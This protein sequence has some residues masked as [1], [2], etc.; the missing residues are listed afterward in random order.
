MLTYLQGEIGIRNKR[1]CT[2]IVKHLA[3]LETPSQDQAEAEQRKRNKVTLCVEGNISAGKSTFLQKLLK[4]SVEL[5]DIIEV[6]PE[7]VD[8]WQ[9]IQDTNGGQPSNLL[10]AF[11]RNPERYAYTFQNYVF[12]TRL[13]QAKD[14]EDCAAPL[15]LLE[16]SVFSDRMVFVRAV[17]EAKWL[18]EMELS[19]YDSWFDPVVSQLQGLVPD[20]FIYLAASP[21]TCMRR[22]SARG[23][24][25]EGGVSLDYLANLHSKHEEWLRSG[26]LRPEELQLLSDPSRNLTQL[27]PNG[28]VG[29]SASCYYSRPPEP[30][31]VRGK[32]FFLNQARQPMLRK[33]IDGLPALYLD[34]DTDIDLERDTDAQSAFARQIR[35]FSDHVRALREARV[36][37]GLVLP[38]EESKRLVMDRCSPEML[39]E[40]L[41][42]RGHDL[43]FRESAQRQF[44]AAS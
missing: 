7:P 6:V 35:D 10:E 23:R 39:Q 9:N 40:T 32:V 20:G 33:H 41:R 29:N 19:I 14:S 2:D 36:K 37:P 17:H 12:V 5:R 26:A 30:E 28:F 22:M 38:S 11:Y 25:E 18:S 16:R 8:K 15:R 42:R 3:D 1:H 44:A 21:E 31:S 4:S 43:T 24:G 13:M 27:Q 34:C